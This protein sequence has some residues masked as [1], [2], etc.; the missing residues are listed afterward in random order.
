MNLLEAENAIVTRLETQIKASL[1]SDFDAPKIQ[2]FPQD[3]LSHFES[4]S[5]NGEILVIFES[6]N[7]ELPE[8]NREGVIVQQ[9]AINWNVWIVHPNL[10]SHT[11]VYSLMEDVKDAL[12]G[13]TV[14]DWDDS[15]PMYMTNADFIDEQGGNWYYG[16]TFQHI[17]EESEA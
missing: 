8:P 14:T 5:P 17:L 13:W 6:L 10:T 11:G 4:I 7:P 15:T 1:S 3:P 16:M 9:I 12:T 2:S